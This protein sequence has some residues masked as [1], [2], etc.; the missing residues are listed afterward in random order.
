MTMSPRPSDS[1]IRCFQIRSR[2][3]CHASALGFF[4]GG[5]GSEPRVVVRGSRSECA[6]MASYRIAEWLEAELQKVL[7]AFKL[8]AFSA[9]PAFAKTKDPRAI[10]EAAMMQADRLFNQAAAD[11]DMKRF[12]SFVADD[13]KFDSAEGLGK[14]A[15]AKAWASF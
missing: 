14:D 1:R 8:V 10:V 2:A 6:T 9:G 12:L 15:V 7:I 4:L 5:V 3:S 13:A 11:R